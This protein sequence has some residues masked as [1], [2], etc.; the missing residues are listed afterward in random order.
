MSRGN[1]RSRES[2][3]YSDLS[4]FP[5]RGKID[6][7]A[8]MS[9]DPGGITLGA[10]ATSIESMATLWTQCEEAELA[11]IFVAPARS[12]CIGLIND[13]SISS[14]SAAVGRPIAGLQTS[15][16]RS[17]LYSADVGRI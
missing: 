12:C 3:V 1:A 16:Q 8:V 17:M 7:A 6:E 13:F 11:F 15:P 14:W 9:A 2:I 10:T 4:L 5:A